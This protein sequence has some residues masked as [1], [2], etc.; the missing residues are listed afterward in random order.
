L[1]FFVL[2][3]ILIPLKTHAQG[4]PEAESH[5]SSGI[6]FAKAHKWAEAEQ[7]LRAAVRAAPRVAVY[8]AQLGSVL[9]LQSK[10][11]EALGSFEKAVELDPVNLNFRREA[12]AVQWQLGLW[13]P[14]EANLRYILE[15]QPGD[16]GAT[17]L[18]GLVAEARGEFRTATKLLS[19]QFDL[20][21]A[22]PDRVVALFH[23]AFQSGDQVNREKA[24]AALRVHASDPLWA[25][26]FGRCIQ[27]AATGGD[28]G[29]SESLFALIPTNHSERTAMGLEIAKLR[30]RNGQFVKAQELLLQLMERGGVSADAEILLGN[31]YEAGQQ[32]QLAARAYQRAMDM[33]PSQV[34]RYEDMISL[35]LDMG[36][37]S[38]AMD[39]LKRALAIAPNDARVWVWKGNAEL[40][41]NSYKDALDSFLRA[42]KL[43]GANADALLGLAG[44]KALAGLHEAAISEYQNGIS[45]FPGDARFYVACAAMFL[46]SANSLELQSQTESLLK[47]AIKLTAHSAEA[48]YQ[49]G[50]LALQRGK[51]AE[52]ET[53][54]RSAIAAD[55][56]MS[57]A[58]FALS[59]VYRRL[60]RAEDATTQFRIYQSLKRRE[61]NPSAVAAS[62]AEKP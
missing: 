40:R 29:M 52:A 57:K 15:N 49:L 39:F 6:S 21:V 30:Y 45:R 58:H 20:V 60:A 55:T 56:G 16:P 19:S 10:W 26:A 59:V 28:V 35:Q 13:D 17:L 9:G 7:E 4:L 37:T 36:K 32:P 44:A 18:L 62:P 46:A 41:T 38:A 12:A 48:H 51:L 54:F 53:E 43:D 31:C 11:R 42:S 5:A 14:A 47:E 33:E 34:S 24:I 8:H 50:Q 22:Q 61:E 27:I 25:N 1:V 3:A 23:S 2:W